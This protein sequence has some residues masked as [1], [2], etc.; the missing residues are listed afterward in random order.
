[1]ALMSSDSVPAVTPLV[2]DPAHELAAAERHPGGGKVAEG[3]VTGIRLLLGILM[4]ALVGLISVEVILRYFLN[5]PLDS[6]TEV[7]SFLFVWLAML[8]AAAAVPL[9]AH[10]AVH[11]LRRYAG[12]IATTS[13]YAVTTI[14]ALAFG[15]FLTLSGYRFTTSLSGETLPV[16]GVSSTWEAAAF[17]TGGALMLVFTLLGAGRDLRRLLARRKG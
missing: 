16:T 11:P 7:A 8:G 5:L 6:V 12:R 17:P 1:M 13:V 3:A 9:G 10:M 14:A 4:L 15:A 2:T